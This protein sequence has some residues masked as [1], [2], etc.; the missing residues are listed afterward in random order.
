[1][2]AVSGLNP[3]SAVRCCAAAANVTGVL[4]FGLAK[5]GVGLY[6]DRPVGLLVALVIGTFVLGALLEARKPLRTSA[7]D[8][9]LNKLRHSHR[10]AARAPLPSELALAVALTGG[11]VLAG[12]AYAGYG[13]TIPSGSTGSSGDGGGDSGG[14]SGDSGG[15]DSG[16]GGGGCGGCGGGGSSGE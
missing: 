11:A 16:R 4:L 5:V 6:R 3:K 7:G 14:S 10:R 1:M 12:T 8:A 15:G 2:F 9:A 13:R